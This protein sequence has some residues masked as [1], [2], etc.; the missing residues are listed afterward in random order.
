MINGWG[1][2]ETVSGVC[3]T[4]AAAYAAISLLRSYVCDFKASQKKNAKTANLLRQ[5]ADV[6]R[7]LSSLLPWPIGLIA[8]LGAVLAFIVALRKLAITLN[9]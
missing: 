6:F 4:F 3:L 8:I 7:K 5:Q 9:F 1:L 2:A